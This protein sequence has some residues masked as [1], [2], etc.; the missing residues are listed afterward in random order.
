[1]A[2]SERTTLI[3]NPATGKG[4]SMKRKRN[5]TLK[6]KLHFG[7]ARQRTAARQSLSKKRHNKAK[8]RRAAPRKQ[9]RSRTRAAAHRPRTKRNLGEVVYLLGA[10]PAKRRKNMGK[11]KTVRRRAVKRANAGRRHTRRNLPVMRRHN[12]RRNPG[13]QTMEYVK[14]GAA[15]VGGGVGSKALT[16]AL[17]STSNTGVMGYAGN[18]GATVALAWASHLAFKDKIITMAVAGGGIAQIITRMIT[19]LTPY[20]SVLSNAGVGDYQT[21]WNFVWPQ[22][23]NVGYP[24]R[25][26]QIPQGWGAAAAAPSTAVVTH[27]TAGKGMGGYDWN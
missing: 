3:A 27:S 26:I 13:G 16:Q 22:R 1:M 24:P 6:Q 10:N 12:R 21:G 23:V 25:G 14:M 11:T 7:S 5:M 17:L 9:N 2:Y 4:R 8:A 19:D 15:I 20:G 18:L